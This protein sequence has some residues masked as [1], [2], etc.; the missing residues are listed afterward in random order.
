MSVAEA[1]MMLGLFVL[2]G[3]FVI[4]FALRDKR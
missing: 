3:A 4:A 2:A 1:V